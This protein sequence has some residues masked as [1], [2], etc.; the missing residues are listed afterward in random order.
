MEVVFS[1][2]DGRA[3]CVANVLGNCVL[4]TNA[5][6]AEHIDQIPKVVRMFN[7]AATSILRSLN[8]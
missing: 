4:V 2:L 7:R 6:S 1:E 5:T 8:V 3:S